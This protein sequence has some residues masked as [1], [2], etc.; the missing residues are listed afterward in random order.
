MENILLNICGNKQQWGVGRKG[1]LKMACANSTKPPK[2]PTT[3]TR[4][5]MVPY[6]HMPNL[7]E[8]PLG[9][10]YYH[11]HWPDRTL[12]TKK[13]VVRRFT[14]VVDGKIYQAVEY[15][16]EEKEQLTGCAK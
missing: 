6:K 1:K 7:V 4:E 5:D 12:R 2:V 3:L 13:L 10:I 8:P 11:C 15:L 14:S 9:S 16:E